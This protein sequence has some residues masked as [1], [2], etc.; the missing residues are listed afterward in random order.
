METRLQHHRQDDARSTLDDAASPT[1]EQKQKEIQPSLTPP[2]TSHNNDRSA[3]ESAIH[4]L[5]EHRKYRLEISEAIFKGEHPIENPV[6]SIPLTLTQYESFL[7][8]L[9]EFHPELEAATDRYRYAAP[10]IIPTKDTITNSQARYDYDSITELLMFR[11]A[12]ASITHGDMIESIKHEISKQIDAIQDGDDA[13]AKFAKD[14][15]NVGNAEVRLVDKIWDKD[16]RTVVVFQSRS[17][18][19]QFRHLGAKRSSVILE[20]AYSQPMESLKKRAEDYIKLSRGKVK[21]VIGIDI[22]RMTKKA[23]VSVWRL[24]LIH[25]TGMEPLIVKA[26]ETTHVCYLL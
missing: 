23:T 6:T 13:S 18:D 16:G 3:V 14:I 22:S 26:E 12:P 15:H 20:A 2:Q 19:G 9:K 1:D 11:M 5:S 17:P 10:L 25:E 7:S 4:L 24:E 8:Q 21:V